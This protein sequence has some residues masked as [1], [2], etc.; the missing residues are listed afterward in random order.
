MPLEPGSSPCSGRP[1]RKSDPSGCAVNKRSRTKSHRCELLW[2]LSL[3]SGLERSIRRMA[4]SR[5]RFAFRNAITD[6]AAPTLPSVSEFRVEPVMSSIHDGSGSFGG[7]GKYGL[8]S[9]SGV[10]LSERQVISS[11]GCRAIIEHSCLWASHGQERPQ[12]RVRCL[13]HAS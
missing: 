8:G 12:R 7:G 4:G 10:S 6:Q 11:S 13:L 2:V 9:T 3:I 5:V 1:F